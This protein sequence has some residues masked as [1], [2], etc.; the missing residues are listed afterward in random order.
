LPAWAET[1]EWRDVLRGRPVTAAP[2]AAWPLASL[3]AGLP[4][5]VL[6]AC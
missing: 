1:M 5:A 4:A 2:G 6:Q 3:L